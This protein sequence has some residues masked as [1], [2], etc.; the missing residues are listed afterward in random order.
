MTLISHFLCF[1]FSH[2][3]SCPFTGSL[4]WI[5]RWICCLL[6]CKFL[7]KDPLT[8]IIIKIHVFS[9]SPPRTF[10]ISSL[11]LMIFVY[12]ASRASFWIINEFLAAPCCVRVTNGIEKERNKIMIAHNNFLGC[13]REGECAMLIN[14][15]EMELDLPFRKIFFMSAKN[16]G[17]ITR[18][19]GLRWQNDHVSA[20]DGSHWLTSF[21]PRRQLSTL[22]MV[23]VTLRFN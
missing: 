12:R 16:F 20:K 19:E 6:M 14:N 3:F 18:W 17:E 23:F 5:L 1:S 21:T 9:V 22:A 10:P 2:I 4:A 8:S 7:H 15:K 11:S 13:E